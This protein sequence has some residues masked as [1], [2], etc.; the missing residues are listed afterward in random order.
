MSVCMCAEARFYVLTPLFM[1]LMW[2]LFKKYDEIME[3]IIF[4]FGFFKG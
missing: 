3:H 1:I 4:G 2:L